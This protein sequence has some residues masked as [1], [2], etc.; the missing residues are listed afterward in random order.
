MVSPGNA[1]G[2]D[3]RG[4]LRRGSVRRGSVRR[5]QVGAP[6]GVKGLLAVL[7]APTLIDFH[8]GGGRELP[9]GDGL[10][11]ALHVGEDE[12]LAASGHK[13]AGACVSSTAIRG[14]ETP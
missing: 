4:K 10:E 12:V 7:P 8:Q 1:G 6:A 3:G 2:G 13:D 11:G 5:G 9:S 14:A